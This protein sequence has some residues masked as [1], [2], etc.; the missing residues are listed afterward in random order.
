MLSFGS[1]NWEIQIHLFYVFL[2]VNKIV[3]VNKVI[4][5]VV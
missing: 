5:E 1:D 3:C 2:L 4:Y